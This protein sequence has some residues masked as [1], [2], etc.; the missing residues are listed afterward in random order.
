MN[1]NIIKNDEKP[2]LAMSKSIHQGPILSRI[3]VLYKNDCK[4]SFGMV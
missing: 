1:N 3:R 4:A 2:T